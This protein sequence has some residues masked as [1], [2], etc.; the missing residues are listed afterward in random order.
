MPRDLR[1]RLIKDFNEETDAYLAAAHEIQKSQSRL[2][3]EREK[4][5][6]QFRGSRFHMRIDRYDVGNYLILTFMN[7]DMRRPS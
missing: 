2:V 3:S 6:L 1:L 4:D 7:V 5:S